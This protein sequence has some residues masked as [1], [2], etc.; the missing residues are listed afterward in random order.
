MS[1]AYVRNPRRPVGVA[2]ELES[3]FH[4]LLHHAVRYLRHTFCKRVTPFII[5]Y[6]D[7][8]QQVD[9]N[10]TRCS[11]TKIRAVTD[12]GI[13]ADNKLLK[14][15]CAPGDPQH[16]LNEL[17]K[18]W[19]VLFTAR[20]GIFAQE[21]D[22]LA[23]SQAAANRLAGASSRAQKKIPGR[24]AF[25]AGEFA[26]SSRKRPNR[27]RLTPG[28]AAAAKATAEMK[29]LAA[30]L[31]EHSETID[32][33]EDHLGEDSDS[34]D[35]E[36]D[37]QEGKKDEE[38][39]LWPTDDVVPDQLK[40]S[41]NPKKQFAAAKSGMMTNLTTGRVSTSSKRP[42]TDT[43]VDTASGSVPATNAPQS[44]SNRPLAWPL[45]RFRR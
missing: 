9:E 14:F 42:R 13:Y 40:S 16:P 35:D 45:V 6:F 38:K 36:Q 17:L 1:V 41:Y 24:R 19:L 15:E 39:S 25:P 12:G 27:V 28:D 22:E 30:K 32:I 3:F 8:F 31:E 7:T 37:E 5:D 4:A 43:S 11:S 2:D 20:Y 34:D 33:F 23:E 26:K 21:Y 44:P 29:E 18:E 10:E